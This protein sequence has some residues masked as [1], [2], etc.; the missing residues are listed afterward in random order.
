ME[1]AIGAIS[2]T[3]IAVSAN[4]KLWELSHEWRDAPADLYKLRDD[5]TRAERFFSEIREQINGSRLMTGPRQRRSSNQTALPLQGQIPPAPPPMH[6]ELAH[7]L[8]SGAVIL[9]NIEDIV[10]IL[11]ADKDANQKSAGKS[12]LDSEVTT[13]NDNKEKSLGKTNVIEMG[14]RRKLR[15]LRHSAKAIRLRKELAHTRANICALLISQNISVSADLSFSMESSQ[16]EI[17]SHITR[18]STSIEASSSSVESAQ[19]AVMSQISALS[20]SIGTLSS[21]LESSQ[22]E[23]MSHISTL[24]RSIETSRDMILVRVEDRIQAMEER[25]L[26]VG[27]QDQHAA[28][29]QDSR[30]ATTLGGLR[31]LITSYSWTMTLQRSMV[32]VMAV[33]YTSWN[34]SPCTDPQCRD[35]QW[36]RGRTRRDFCLAYQL[37]DWLARTSVSAFFSTNLNGSPQMNIRVYNRR[38]WEL[39]GPQDLITRGDS[40]R[41]V[42]PSYPRAF[43]RMLV[44]EK[45][46]K[47]FASIFPVHKYIEES[48]F[49]PLHQAVLGVT[50]VDLE[51]MLQ[52]P[53]HASR[54]DAKSSDGFTALHLAALRGDSQAAKL[55]IRAGA[56]LDAKTADKQTPPL[57]YAAR[58]NH[59]KAAQALLDAGADVHIRDHEGG[60]PIHVATLFDK[61]ES[62][63]M[64]ALLLKHG[65]SVHSRDI[66]G[67]TPIQ[68]IQH[69]GSIGAA[70]YLLQNGADPNGASPNTSPPIH[71][72]IE[73]SRRGMV[74]LLLE[75]GADISILDDEW[76]TVLHKLALYGDAQ[77]MHIFTGLPFRGITSSQ[78]DKFEKTPLNYLNERNPSPEIRRAFNSLLESVERQNNNDL[79]VGIDDLTSD[80]EFFDAVEDFHD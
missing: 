62:K 75:H 32:G 55:L 13:S 77:M 23:V 68:Y 56:H 61:D 22:K 44:D 5:V 37:P 15:W 50:H 71:I 53:I 35:M 78:K 8:E 69:R 3:R 43:E 26:L 18:L 2:V 11:A 16:K 7:L 4:S 46:N 28:I 52:D 40:L 63:D 66:G 30:P 47:G 38:G 45:R 70:R 9:R 54:V 14:K 79:S 48:D 76:E 1:I 25:M 27:I 67:N 6:S 29:E 73:A 33:A 17:M 58:Y 51:K 34:S 80:N 60:Q 12:K 36:Q 21:S 19:E 57:F 39:N 65:A 74:E 20:T 64:L 59:V 72:A 24:S 49:T 41:K 31:H 42:A 10:D